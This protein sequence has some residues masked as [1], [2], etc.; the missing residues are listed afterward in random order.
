MGFSLR[1]FNIVTIGLLVPVIL[2]ACGGGGAQSTTD[3]TNSEVVDSVDIG[4]GGGGLFQTGAVEAELVSADADGAS[5]DLEVVVV[6]NN[7]IAVTDQ[8]LVTFYSPCVSSGLAS[9]ESIQ[10]STVAGRASTTYSSGS[11]TGVDTVIASISIGGVPISA[12]VDL[13]I[14]AAIAVAGGGT[15]VTALSIGSGTGTDFTEGVL[16]ASS[17]NLQAGASVT[18]SANVVNSENEPFVDVVEVDFTSGCV[19]TGLAEFSFPTVR[20]NGG[21]AT[22]V[23]TAAGCS[24]EDTVSARGAFQGQVLDAEVVINIAPDSVLGIEFVSNSESTLAISGIG[25]DETSLVTFRIVGAQGAP[26]VGETVSFELSNTAGGASL[27][28]GTETGQTN[29]SGEVST[30]V[31]SGTVNSSFRVIATHSVS[32]VQGFSEDISIS[33]GVPVSHS[34]DLSITPHNPKAWNVNQELVQVTANVSDQFGNPPPDGTR[35]S[36]RSVEIGTIQSSC[37]LVGGVCSVEWR[38]SGDR[39]EIT[40]D[41]N[42]RQGRATIIGFMS[43]AEDFDDFNANGLFDFGSADEVASV[44]DLPEAFTD[45]NENGVYDFGEDFI[46]SF[47]NNPAPTEDDGGALN[48][49][50]D[51]VGDGMYNGPCSEVINSDC[52]VSLLQSAT[53]WDEA[54][55]A[56]SSPVVQICDLG[57]LPPIGQEIGADL[58]NS[59]SFVVSGVVICDE[60]HNSL[61]LE[62]SIE[63]SALNVGLFGVALYSVPSN[64]TEPTAPFGITITP[65]GPINA[66]AVFNLR[67]SVPGEVAQVYSWPVDETAFGN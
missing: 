47:L 53:I 13:E 9:F 38:S 25:G 46:D 2:G 3:G 60:N 51:A 29:N 52:P 44:V 40:P 55:I 32:G 61:P 65:D 41:T 50:Y 15:G 64:T 36:F 19:S 16:G 43:G 23:Y 21:L 45:Q 22:T 14:D 62:T 42:G 1:L 56:L 10:V 34:F 48:G 6:G 31:Q 30:V 7:N 17:L 11:C 27:A 37:E 24:G 58:I 8:Y 54:V 26:I 59:D 18:I 5:W 67:V 35:V 4:S 39:G 57:N 12:Q 20:T 66:S 49:V 33:T 63:F 28:E